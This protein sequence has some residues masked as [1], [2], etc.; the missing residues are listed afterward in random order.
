MASARAGKTLEEVGQEL[1]VTR[2]RVRQIE[3]NALAKARI[4]SRHIA[5]V[6]CLGNGAASL[7]KQYL[8]LAY[9]RVDGCPFRCFIKSAGIGPSVS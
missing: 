1:G 7:F 9:V 3:M 2:E 5:I 6:D 4:L 8:Y